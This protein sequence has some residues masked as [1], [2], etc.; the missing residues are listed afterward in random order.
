MSQL[1]PKM[2]LRV[3]VMSDTNGNVLYRAG[4]EKVPGGEN[5]K[6]CRHSKGH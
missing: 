5:W 2:N 1:Y 4:K 6:G 3:F